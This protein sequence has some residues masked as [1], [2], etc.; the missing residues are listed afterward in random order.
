[1]T[2]SQDIWDA[3]R[4][5]QSKQ[6]LP[7]IPPHPHSQVQSY[8]V[9]AFPPVMREL[10]QS[11]H[12]ETL[13]PVEMIGSTVLAAAAI[14]CQP[15]INVSL[16]FSGKPEPCSLYLM[17]IAESGEGKSTVSNRIMSPFE[18]FSREMKQKYQNILTEYRK[19]YNI[20]NL[21]KK[22]LERE[23]QKKYRRGES[24]EQDICDLNEHDENQPEKPI[25]LNFLYGDT[26]PKTIIQGLSEYPVAGI[27]LDEAIIFFKGFLKN[28]LGLMNNAWDGKRYRLSRSNEESYDIHPCVTLYLMSQSTVLKDYIEKHGEIAKGSG[29]FSR[30]LF[31]KIK[32]TIGTRPVDTDYRRSEEALKSFHDVVNKLLKKQVAHFYEN[33]LTRKTLELTHDAVN[34]WR[35]RQSEIQRKI[36]TE[37]EWSHIRDIGSK[38]GANMLRVAA[39]LQY[40]SDL[41]SNQISE[42]HLA[43]AYKIVNWHLHQASEL[44]YS[45]SEVYQFEQDVYE[46]FSWIKDKFIQTNDSPIRKNHILQAG[47]NRLRHSHILDPL[48]DQLIAL[49]CICSFKA[50]PNSVEY[51]AMPMR[52]NSSM[53]N[54]PHN[55]IVNGHPYILRNFSNTRG[56]YDNSIFENSK[57]YY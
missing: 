13:I 19:E 8:P 38:A 54:V 9:D 24:T 6:L 45:G 48:L 22:V 25:C 43:S 30:F 50:T 18:D 57:L 12:D 20:W 10:I 23:Y 46:L 4:F 44:F 47:P 28:N 5:G 33:D 26:T 36:A 34:I 15:H 14:A 1:M 42:I 17:T 3:C 41:D 29:F 27:I 56:R 40:F 55:L 51:I 53:W 2:M 39:I 32:S 49:G 37:K 35:D 7:Q 11:Y 16:P 31:T 52:S 21:Q